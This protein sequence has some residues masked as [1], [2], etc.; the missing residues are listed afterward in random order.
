MNWLQRSKYGY[1]WLTLIFFLLSLIG[2]WLF[3]WFA[4][5]NEQHA[6]NAPV[7]VGDYAVEMTRDTLENWQSEFL[8]PMWQVGG[9]AVLLYVGSPQSKEARSGTKRRSTRSS[10]RWIVSR[11]KNASPPSTASST[12]P[13]R[14]CSLFCRGRRAFLPY[15]LTLRIADA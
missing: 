2:H 4:Y 14:P 15:H 5:V 3:G 6:L 11:A 10:K 12:K 9:L 13:E 1:L 8:Q 7:S